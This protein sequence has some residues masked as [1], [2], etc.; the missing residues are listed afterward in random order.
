M[1]QG[2][3]RRGTKNGA[4]RLDEHKVR[5]LR[6]QYRPYVNGY[7]KLAREFGISVTAAKQAINGETWGWLD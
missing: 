5:Q 1:S 7:I 2:E 3:K 6:Q 4:S